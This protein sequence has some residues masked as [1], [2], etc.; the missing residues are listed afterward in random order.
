MLL[1]AVIV[2]VCWAFWTNN[3]TRL[4][5][6][7]RQNLL[8]DETK[9]LGKPEQELIWELMQAI[10][11]ESGF[12]L[13]V[14]ILNRPPRLEAHD[15]QRIYLDVLPGQRRAFLTLPPL[16]RR[17][18]GGEFVRDMERSLEQ[19][20]AESRWQAALGPAVNALRLKLAEVTR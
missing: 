19:G 3:Q 20:F 13:E 11:K 15:A 2:V 18:L 7:A 16:A 4:A 10:R 17:A 14:H 1:T 5:D 12:I 6:M 8:S 9:S